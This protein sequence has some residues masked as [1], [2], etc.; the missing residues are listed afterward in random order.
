MSA[1]VWGEVANAALQ[2]TSAYL[3]Y[4]SQRQAN[5]TNIRN[6]REQRE[7]EREMSNTAVQ[8]RARDIELAGG[9]RALAFVNGSEATTPVYTPARVEAPH[10]DAPRFNTAALMQKVQ[11]DN[12]KSQTYKNS[13]ETESVAI[14]NRFKQAVLDG[15]IQYTNLGQAQDYSNKV[16]QGEKIRAEIANLASEKTARDIANYI[17]NNTKEDVITAVKTGAMLKQLEIPGGENSAAWQLIKKRILEWVDKTTNNDTE[18]G[19]FHP[20][21]MY[22]KGKWR[23]NK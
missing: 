11:L 2:A 4:D 7:F 8:R 9:N 1:A 16:A 21:L 23:I 22:E 10:I 5:L 20:E 3:N 15:K 19:P 13:A 17:A 18:Y 12:L 6:S 14:D